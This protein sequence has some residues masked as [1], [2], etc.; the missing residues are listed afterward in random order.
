MLE[1]NRKARLDFMIVNEPIAFVFDCD[2]DGDKWNTIY[3]DD[4]L[5][6]CNNSLLD[7]ADSDSFFVSMF[8]N[9]NLG[10]WAVELFKS[11]CME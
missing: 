7:N 8:E 1:Q 11:E 5:D 4:V 6:C 9:G 3:L 10:E 2:D